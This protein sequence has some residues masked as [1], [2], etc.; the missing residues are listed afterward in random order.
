MDPTTQKV[1][2]K[3]RDRASMYLLIAT[4]V[5]AVIAGIALYLPRLFSTP[6]SP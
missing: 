4:L 2:T 1:M 3:R 5:V 6:V